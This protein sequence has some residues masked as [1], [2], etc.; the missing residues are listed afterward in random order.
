MTLMLHAEQKHIRLAALRFFRACI[1]RSDDFYNRYLIKNGA[2]S[3]IIDLAKIETQA[4]NLLASACLDLF[5][6]LRRVS[7]V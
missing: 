4:D 1:G 6:Y 3:D 7:T 5:E 2:F